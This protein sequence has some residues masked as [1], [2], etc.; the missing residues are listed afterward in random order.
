MLF[1][2]GVRRYPPI[3]VLVGLAAD[4]PH[5]NKFALPYLLN[6]IGTHYVNFDPTTFAQVAFLPA[7]RP[8]GKTTMAKPGSVS[9][10]LIDKGVSELICQVFTNQSCSILGFSVV[11]PSIANPEIAAKL[12]IQSDPPMNSL[13][14]ALLGNAS[15]DIDTSRRMFEVGHSQTHDRRT[16]VLTY[17]YLATQVGHAP[18][19]SYGQLQNASFIP[20][21]TE[22]DVQMFSPSSVYFSKAEGSDALYG[23]AFT[24]VDFG[25]Q[26]NTF[27]RYCGVRSEP[28]VKGELPACW[29]S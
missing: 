23:S 26:A 4:Q 17:Q 14:S 11:A 1:S 22:R 6:H 7:V 9:A 28:S 21:K 3:D 27:L 16:I 19:S 24:F 10:V 12:R 20:V 13:V 18:S 5:S 15:K 8:N 2:L 25:E 29:P